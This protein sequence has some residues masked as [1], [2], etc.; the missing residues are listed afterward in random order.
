MALFLVCFPL[1]IFIFVV[2]FF[3]NREIAA[4]KELVNGDAG[5]G[6]LRSSKS[7][8]LL[9]GLPLL[10]LLLCRA[11]LRGGVKFRLEL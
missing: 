10:L 11:Y 7:F 1:Q 9:L 3:A 2:A 4:R 6:G 5:R 8:R